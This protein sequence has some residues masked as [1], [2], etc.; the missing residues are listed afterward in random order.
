M[1][2]RTR[3]AV[4][5]SALAGFSFV[6]V[7]CATGAEP[8]DAAREQRIVTLMDELP[9][10][11]ESEFEALD[12]ESLGMLTGR[13]DVSNAEAASSAGVGAG[14]ETEFEAGGAT[15]GKLSG[16][17]DG[18][19]F[20][21]YGVCAGAAGAAQVHVVGLGNY[22]MPCTA[23]GEGWQVLPLVEDQVLAGTELTLQVSGEPFR[24]AWSIGVAEH[25]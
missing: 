23:D 7:G 10:A 8:Y 5:V 6:A 16:Y 25:P 15:T 3:T 4:I 18:Q 11:I 1:G 19:V 2:V 13:G 22:E 17:R 14:A 21:L 24:A 9:E 12:I 20:S